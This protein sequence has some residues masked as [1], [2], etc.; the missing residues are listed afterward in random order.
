MCVADYRRCGAV[1]HPLFHPRGN[2]AVIQRCSG[3]LTGEYKTTTLPP[4]PSTTITTKNAAVVTTPEPPP[5]AEGPDQ[6]P[7]RPGTG[8]VAVL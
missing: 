4:P 6:T 8:C 1:Q 7:A 5:A 3:T 2:E